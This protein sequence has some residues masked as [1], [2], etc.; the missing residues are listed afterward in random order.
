VQLASTIDNTSNS[1]NAICPELLFFIFSLLSNFFV[2]IYS[3][4]PAKTPLSR[5]KPPEWYVQLATN[6]RG[7]TVEINN[8]EARFNK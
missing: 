6:T 5:N 1:A 8:N 2:G 4:P 7:I 3:M